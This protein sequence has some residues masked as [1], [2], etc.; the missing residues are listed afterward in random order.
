MLKGGRKDDGKEVLATSIRQSWVCV[1][2]ACPL[3]VDARKAGG[4]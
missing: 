4:R 3:N 2:W 1:V